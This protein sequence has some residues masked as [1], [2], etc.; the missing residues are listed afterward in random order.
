M[1][2]FSDDVMD[3]NQNP[4][5]ESPESNDEARHLSGSKLY[6]LAL[7]LLLTAFTLTLD[8]SIMATAIPKIT[9]DFHTINDIGWYGAGYL[10]TLTSLQPTSGRIY[11]HFSLKPAYLAFLAVFAFGSL[12]CG[13]AVSSTMLIVGRAIA[14]MGGS[15]IINGAMTIIG[16]EAPPEKRPILLGLLFAL[17][18][19]GQVVGPLLGGALTQH[20][21]W[22][23]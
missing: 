20:A 18:G 4:T 22:R 17:S 2:T 16:V 12:L 1:A 14:G 9:D 10:T 7:A 19:L 21:S 3:N 13:T 5:P 11:T 8:M 15:G 23:W 6:A